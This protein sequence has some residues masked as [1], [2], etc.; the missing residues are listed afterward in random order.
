[1]SVGTYFAHLVSLGRQRYI[2]E[3]SYRPVSRL[4]STVVL[5]D[6]PCYLRKATVM[7]SARL[8]SR[9]ATLLCAITLLALGLVAQAQ[10]LTPNGS[11]SGTLNA[12]TPEIA[13]S[14]TAPNDGDVT[15]TI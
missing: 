14:F 6:F 10:V 1:M 13:Y 11:V 7:T 8:L 5:P 12:A 3:Q 15:L 4:P 2:N 9:M